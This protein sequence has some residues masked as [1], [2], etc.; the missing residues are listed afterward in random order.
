MK[1][2]NLFTAMLLISAISIVSCQKDNPEDVRFKTE[3]SGVVQKGPFNAGTSVVAFELNKSMVQTDLSFSTQITA[4]NGSFEIKNIDLSSTLVELKADGYYF[5]EVT[6]ETS[7]SPLTLFALAD[8]SS[9][10]QVNVNILS[11]LEKPRV[12][13]LMSKGSTFA[14]AKSTAQQ[15]ILKA[16]NLEGSGIG[17]SEALN[18]SQQGEGNA[19]LL[20]ISAI[21][22]GFR[23]V[24]DL[25]ELLTKV[26]SDLKEDGLINDATLQTAIVSH[27]IFIDPVQIRNNLVAK[28]Q[29]AGT[30]AQVP[31]FKQHVDRFVSNTAFVPASIFKYPENSISGKNILNDKLSSFITGFET[32]YSLAAETV[33]GVGLKIELQ[34]IETPEKSYGAWGFSGLNVQN[35]RATIY[36]SETDKQE[37]EVI[38][39][40]QPSDVRFYF[41]EPG[42]KIRITYFEGNRTWSRVITTV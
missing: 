25:S 5:N 39:P 9:R 26:A 35:W 33:K 41:F 14:E 20:A 21:L 22:Q 11:H 6:G 13:Y 23:S 36:D 18:I 37:F 15:D 10:N 40:G 12:E 24:A 27:A 3:I 7:S 19:K 31:D 38:N 17:A 1:T 16:F 2:K 28:Y 34:I 42:Q 29:T 4:N 32:Q 30:T 8:L